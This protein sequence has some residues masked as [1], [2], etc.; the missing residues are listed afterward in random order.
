MVTRSEIHCNST[1]KQNNKERKGNRNTVRV[2]EG[3]AHLQ[4]TILIYATEGTIHIHI[5]IP[6]TLQWLIGNM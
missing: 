1:G 2:G 3:G 5:D 4:D 6:G